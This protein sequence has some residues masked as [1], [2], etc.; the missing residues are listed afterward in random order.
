MSDQAPSCQRDAAASPDTR[1]PAGRCPRLIVIFLSVTVLI[2]G[3]DL[4]SKYLAFHHVADQPVRLGEPGA[5][6]TMYSHEPV[7]VVPGVLSLKLTVNEGAVFG[8]GQGNR[9][10]FIAVSIVAA[11]VLLSIF[12]RSSAR[13]YIL[14]LA[15]ALVL[16]GALGNLYDRAV[17]GMV[18]DMFWIFPGAT[19]PFGLTWPGGDHRLYPWV[20][21]VADVALVVGV[22]TLVAITWFGEL[23]QQGEQKADD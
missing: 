13:A 3:V 10:F 2:L 23:R 18:R 21:N 14:H 9:L 11:I 15:L 20:F 6:A 17:Y 5:T 19:L 8:L 16:A 4:A 12:Y 1:A 7:T 22:L